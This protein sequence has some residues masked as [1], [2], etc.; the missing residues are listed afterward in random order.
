MKNRGIF[1]HSNLFGRALD[2]CEGLDDDKIA[3][4]DG[5]DLIVSTIYKKDPLSVVANV[6]DELNHII[7]LKRGTT[8]FSGV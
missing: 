5:S 6:F 7:E 4:E 3:S 8:E 1:L 2:L